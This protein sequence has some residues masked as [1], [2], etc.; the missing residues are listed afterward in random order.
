MPRTLTRAATPRYRN[1]PQ[2]LG[3]DQ[4]LSLFLTENLLT[5]RAH[6]MFPTNGTGPDEDVNVYLAHLLATFMTAD[7]EPGV[8]R[9]SEP[10]F[11]PP[12]HSASRGSRADYY[13]ANADHRLLYLGLF[14]RGEGLRRRPTLF[15]LSPTETR[16][17]DLAAGRA[18]YAAAASHLRPQNGSQRALVAIWQKLADN[19]EDYVHVLSALAT[20]QLGLGATLSSADLSRLTPAD[21]TADTRAVAALLRQPPPAAALDALLDLWLEQEKNPD[22][23]TSARLQAMADRL[24]VRLKTGP[25]SGP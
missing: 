15:G 6:S 8:G 10:L 22:P 7:L 17:R 9:M 25:A 4:P 21:T 11:T 23:V 16:Q 24:G 18:C 12:P 13:R 1:L 5:A 3:P 2:A 20:R 19:F 14:D